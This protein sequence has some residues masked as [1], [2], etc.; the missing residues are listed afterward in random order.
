MA[1]LSDAHGSVYKVQEN[2][3][4]Y[5]FL[6]TAMAYLKVSS[7][8]ADAWLKVLPKTKQI[9]IKLD[10]LKEVCLSQLEKKNICIYT[11]ILLNYP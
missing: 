6:H 5:R 7:S 1:V 11:Y 10:S 4:E 2:L 8:S 9:Y 3:F